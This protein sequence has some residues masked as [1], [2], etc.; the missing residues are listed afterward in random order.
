MK[1]HE[2]AGQSEKVLAEA[3]SDQEGIEVARS[4]KDILLP[5]RKYV[6]DLLSEAG[7]LSYR[8]IDSLMDVNMKLL[9]NQRSF[10]RMLGGIGDW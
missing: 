2:G 6:L 5:Q 7:M 8:S 4:K 3:L 1:W 10:L 9:P